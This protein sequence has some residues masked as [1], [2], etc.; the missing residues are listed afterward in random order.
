[1]L[2]LETARDRRLFAQPSLGALA[3]SR[4][5]G[6]L[7]TLLLRHPVS[8]HPGHPTI[9]KKK[10]DDF[11][12]SHQEVVSTKPYIDMTGVLYVNLYDMGQNSTKSMARRP[13]EKGQIT[14][15]RCALFFTL[16]L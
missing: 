10:C 15:H 4:R 9:I 5:M 14:T 16:E 13:S 8:G 12:L 3:G 11:D 7:L 2:Y 1:M 6:K